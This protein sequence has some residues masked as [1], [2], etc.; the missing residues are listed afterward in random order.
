[1]KEIENVGSFIQLGGKSK[2]SQICS[3][4][5]DFNGIWEEEDRKAMNRNAE[6]CISCGFPTLK[7]PKNGV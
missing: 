3:S 6:S 4:Y 2:L 5:E 7:L 1:M